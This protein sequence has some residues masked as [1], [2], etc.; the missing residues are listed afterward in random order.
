MKAEI[1]SI[2][3][4]VAL[5]RIAD[6][7]A[8][9]LSQRLTEIGY[10]MTRHTVVADTREEILRALEDTRGRA[11]VVMV[12]GGL[13]PTQDDMTREAL[14]EFGG[15]PLAR[16]AEAE[17]SL[18]AFFERVGRPMVS[19]N[20]RQTLVPEG[21]AIVPN[22]RG[23]A[24]GF[25]LTVDKAEYV[26]LP[27]VPLEMK[28]MF[29]QAAGPRLREIARSFAAVRQLRV[30]GA[31][32][33]TVGELLGDLMDRGG[34]PDVGTQVDSGTISVRV[35]A[36]A[37]SEEEARRL[38][39]EAAEEARRR[40]GERIVFG[41]GEEE[42][43]EA[44]ACELERAG[45]TIALAE[46]CTGGQASA[47]LTDVPGSS[48]FFLEG[49]VTYSNASKTARLDVPPE[50]I[51]AK[52]AV[53]AEVAEAMARGMRERSGADIALGMTGIA[54]P[55]GGTP[56]KPVGLVYIALSDAEGTMCEAYRSVGRRREVKTR[57]AR[58]ALNL[59][60]LRLK[61]RPTKK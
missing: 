36:R 41:E 24:V 20:L 22:P 58:Y 33:S 2:G 31:G 32:E 21:A 40:L 18:R 34:N 48:A 25:A 61:S 53:S 52:G 26:A 11:A 15:V 7:N 17:Q 3:S 54:G 44:L 10:E 55:G 57:A 28:L 13:G 60:R 29:E 59:A 37:D 16:S 5:G 45:L 8:A 30:F 51:Q 19:S 49:C 43:E 27:G 23:T 50:L 35:V 6:T 4:E 56:A 39:D 12:T 14:A 38:A 47:Y 46:S 9:W 1:L 42:V